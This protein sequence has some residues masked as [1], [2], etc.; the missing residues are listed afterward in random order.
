MTKNV[1]R[2]KAK[3]TWTKSGEL[4]AEVQGE[5]NVVEQAQGKRTCLSGCTQKS[6]RLH[7]Q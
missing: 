1:G 4:G 5:S 7:P 2:V 6:G 3:K